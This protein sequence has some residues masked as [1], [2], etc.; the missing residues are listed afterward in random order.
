[1]M[2]TEMNGPSSFEV[3]GRGNNLYLIQRRWLGKKEGY[4]GWQALVRN[5][6]AWTDTGYYADTAEEILRKMRADGKVA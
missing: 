1:M 3:H 5:G 2:G 6:P 4:R